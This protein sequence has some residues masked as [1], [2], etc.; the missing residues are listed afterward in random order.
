MTPSAADI[1][2]LSS[3]H[4]CAWKMSHP[5]INI[6][7]IHIQ[8][9]FYCAHKMLATALKHIV[10]S[11]GVFKR[12]KLHS[13][14][15]KMNGLA[16]LMWVHFFLFERG[17]FLPA[18]VPKAGGENQLYSTICQLP[19][20]TFNSNKMYGSSFQRILPVKS[21]PMNVV[22]NATI[23]SDFDLWFNLSLRVWNIN[24]EACW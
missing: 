11:E 10:F 7:L 14:R 5:Y 9:Q 18:A 8:W 15:N 3:K 20:E 1:L 12:L 23:V 13:N 4:P 17:I 22:V 21:I 2:T 24:T 19:L 16:G 6:H